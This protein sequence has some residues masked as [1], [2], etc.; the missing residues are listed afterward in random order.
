GN[1]TPVAFLAYPEHP[2]CITDA[3]TDI[4]AFEEFPG[5]DRAVVLFPSSFDQEEFFGVLSKSR[6]E[7][8]TLSILFVNDVPRL[9]VLSFPIKRVLLEQN[10]CHLNRV[11]TYFLPVDFNG[12]WPW[13]G[14]A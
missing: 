6:V 10:H 8:E 7:R 2:V 13:D 11:H 12:I 14:S 1:E 5:A 4:L 3:V 9:P